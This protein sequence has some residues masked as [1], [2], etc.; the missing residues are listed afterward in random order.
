M[1]VDGV[2]S[3]HADGVVGSALRCP[4]KFQIGVIAFLNIVDVLG[5]AGDDLRGP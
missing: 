3:P 1:A 5:Q 4:G 2:G